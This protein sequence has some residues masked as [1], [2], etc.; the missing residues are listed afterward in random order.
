MKKL[1]NLNKEKY[2]LEPQRMGELVGGKKVIECTGTEVNIKYTGSKREY[3]GTSDRITY[4]SLRD[5]I[6]DISSK[7]EV[8]DGPNDIAK[9]NSTGCNCYN[10]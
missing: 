8:F 9:L 3:P 5:A 6:H 2:L 10:W 4:D 1:D 7:I